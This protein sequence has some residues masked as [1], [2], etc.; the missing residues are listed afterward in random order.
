RSTFEQPFGGRVHDPN[1]V[2]GVTDEDRLRHDLENG[3]QLSGR[4][5]RRW[6]SRRRAGPNLSP[7]RAPVRRWAALDHRMGR[8]SFPRSSTMIRL[9]GLPTGP[10]TPEP[11]C[12]RIAGD[13]RPTRALPG[14]PPVPARPLRARDI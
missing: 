1:A 4:S 6:A 9:G 11:P 13:S 7:W 3:P 2:V 5:D 14:C 10:P 8:L 12:A